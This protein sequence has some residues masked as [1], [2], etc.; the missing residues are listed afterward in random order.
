M[1]RECVVDALA[2]VVFSS[3]ISVR[4]G[5]CVVRNGMCATPDTPRVFFFF[6]FLARRQ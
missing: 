4:H 3:G 5:V 1:A 6:F 2:A